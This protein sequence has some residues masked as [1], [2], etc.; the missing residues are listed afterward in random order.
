MRKS[1]MQKI[2]LNRETLRHLEPVKL[3]EV[4]AGIVSFPGLCTT[5]TGDQPSCL[6]AC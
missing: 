4:G 5:H 3:A 6:A 1:K 2:S